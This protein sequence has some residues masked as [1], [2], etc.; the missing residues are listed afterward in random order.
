MNKYLVSADI[1]GI[2]GVINKEFTSSSGKYYSLGQKYM[3]SDVNAVV[4]GILSADHDAM[5]VVRD[6]HGRASN[7]DLERLHPRAHIIQGWGN[8]VNMVETID[9]TYK[10]VFCVGYHAGGHDNDAVLSHTMAID[11]QGIKVNGVALNETG[12]V[13]LCAGDCGVPVAFVSGDDHAVCEA[14][15]QLGKDFIGVEVKKSLARDAALSLPLEYAKSLLEKG[16]YE[17]TV[18][19]ERNKIVPFILPAPLTVEVQ[20]Y[21]TGF[22]ISKFARLKAMLSFD[23]EYVFSGENYV[24]KYTTK[25]S[26]EAFQRLDLILCLIYTIK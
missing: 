17:A 13:A 23:K 4:A 14:R 16:A 8:S 9:A 12:V 10:G 1:E 21:N 19:L 3:T 18:S 24:I 7:L 15:Q 11:I 25:T 2:T 6:A 20:F 5:V 26:T 22:F